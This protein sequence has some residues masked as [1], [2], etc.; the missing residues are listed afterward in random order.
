MV[1]ILDIYDSRIAEGNIIAAYTADL[2]YEKAFIYE[3]PLDGTGTFTKIVLP[4]RYIEN[5]ESVI[6]WH[7][8]SA[9]APWTIL[10]TVISTVIEQP[11]LWQRLDL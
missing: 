8:L 4:P 2:N 5:N 11:N 6:V 10:L 7:S 9:I 1:Q 3:G